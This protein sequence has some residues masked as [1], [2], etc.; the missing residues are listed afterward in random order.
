MQLTLKKISN[1]CRMGAVGFFWVAGLLV[2]G[3]DSHYMP[4]V[5]GA[6]LILFTGASLIMGRRFHAGGQER[7]RILYPG[8][9]AGSVGPKNRD[10]DRMGQAKQ[11]SD[12]KVQGNRYALSASG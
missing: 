4:W 2:A 5:N 1:N 10:Q 12:R 7:G 6:G 9:S 11:P 3:S 8:F